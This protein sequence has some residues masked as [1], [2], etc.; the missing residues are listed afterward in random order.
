MPGWLGSGGIIIVNDSSSLTI[1]SVA[2][3]D[4]FDQVVSLLHCFAVLCISPPFKIFFT[5]YFWFSTISPPFKI[6]LFPL[7]KLFAGGLEVHPPGHKTS[8]LAGS[9]D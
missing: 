6:F 3:H 5:P 4:G 9:G 2:C 7:A 1:K 8:V